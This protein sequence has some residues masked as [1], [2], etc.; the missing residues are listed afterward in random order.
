MIVWLNGPFGV[1]KTTTSRLLQERAG[2][3]VFDP[4]HVGYLVGGHFRDIDHDD[5][6]DLPPWRALV[7]K[8]ADELLRHRG[9]DLLL[10]VQTVVREDYWSELAGG[11]AALGHTMFHVVLDCD[12]TVLRDRIRADEV[13][14]D[15]LRWRLDHVERF[16]EARAWL[17]SSADLVIDTSATPADDVAEAIVEALRA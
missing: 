16:G 6:Q 9:T 15:A 10:A 12:A 2:W 11:F 14:R 1:G 8:V 17:R 5:F 3:P 13:E 4:E 7:P